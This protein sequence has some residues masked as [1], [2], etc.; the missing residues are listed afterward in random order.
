MRLS[1]CI[2]I[3]EIFFFLDFCENL[4]MSGREQ[5]IISQ[6]MPVI[7]ELVNDPNQHVKTAL[8]SVVMGLAP[9]VGKE[10]TVEHLLP[11]YLL[12][13]KDETAE[14]RLNIISSLDKV[15]CMWWSALAWFLAFVKIV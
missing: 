9:V 15:H 10:Q 6:M 14:V 12:L 3:I 2:E 4:P 5:L 7:K 1:S 8:A 13:L 11:M